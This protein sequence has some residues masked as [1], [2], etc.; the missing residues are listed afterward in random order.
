MIKVEVYI[1]NTYVKD[2]EDYLDLSSLKNLEA[3]PW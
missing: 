2:P 1:E 3:I